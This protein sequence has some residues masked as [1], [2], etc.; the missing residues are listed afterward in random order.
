M[1]MALG[2][3]GQWPAHPGGAAVLCPYHITI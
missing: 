2:N 3:A 1:N